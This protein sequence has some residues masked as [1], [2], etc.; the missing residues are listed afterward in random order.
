MRFNMSPR[1]TRIVVK[2]GLCFSAHRMVVESDDRYILRHLSPCSLSARIAPNATLS[3]AATIGGRQFTPAAE[4]DGWH[5][6][7]SLVKIAVQ[8]PIR[9]DAASRTCAC[10]CGSPSYLVFPES[11][12]MSP[13]IIRFGMPD[14]GE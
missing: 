8:H 10:H 9:V 1:S 11:R 7:R 14:T 2:A 5:Y 3:L 6:N 4:I 13:L 12:F